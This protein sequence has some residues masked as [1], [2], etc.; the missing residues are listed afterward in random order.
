M[1]IV[2]SDKPQEFC[3][4]SINT[5]DGIYITAQLELPRSLS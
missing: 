4:K 1:L 3:P 5:L 2:Q